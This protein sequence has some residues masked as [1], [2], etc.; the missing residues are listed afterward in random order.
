[1][2]GL[3]ELSK[4]YQRITTG[5]AELPNGARITYT[6]D[7]PALVTALHSWF[8]AQVSD[9]GSHAEHG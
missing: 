4:G 8:D 9:H 1:M 3:S 2:P 6:T 5:Y 7:D